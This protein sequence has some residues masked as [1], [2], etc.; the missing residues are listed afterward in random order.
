MII[1]I[2]FLIIQNFS[3]AKNIFLI[4]K[5]KY[6]ARLVNS[7]DYCR[8]ESIGFLSYIKNKHQIKNSIKINNYFISPDPSWFFYKANSK[9]IIKDKM[10]LLGFE[11]NLEINF[12]N[13]KNIFRS[14]R[15]IKIL[16]NIKNISFYIRSANSQKKIKFY[17]YQEIFGEKKLIYSSDFVTIK[18]KENIIAINKSI[19]DT[20]NNSNI[21]I[22]FK[23]YNNDLF[24]EIENLKLSIPN[25]IN[26]ENHVIYEKFKNCYLI[27][28]ND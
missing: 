14:N 22:E 25:D 6:D 10:V 4:Y 28:K 24:K 2:T 13:Q 11:K 3:V 23:N 17:I 21:I 19:A 20:F 15:S 1:L 8:N 26:L 18:N 16:D 7:Y 5:N 12:K 27:S 9:N